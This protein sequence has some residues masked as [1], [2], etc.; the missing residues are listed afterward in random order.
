M[1]TDRIIKQKVPSATGLFVLVV[2]FLISVSSDLVKVVIKE[3]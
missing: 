1:S 3:P 2:C